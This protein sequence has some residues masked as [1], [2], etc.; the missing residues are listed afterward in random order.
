VETDVLYFT[1][2]VRDFFLSFFLV[3]LDFA[4]IGGF[5]NFLAAKQ[6]CKIVAIRLMEL[7]MQVKQ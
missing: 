5:L 3:F 7:R 4:S 6:G 1:L 2:F